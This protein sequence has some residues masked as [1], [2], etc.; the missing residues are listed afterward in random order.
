MWDIYIAK[1]TAD[2]FMFVALSAE[3][4]LSNYGIV[5]IRHHTFRFRV[6]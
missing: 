2:L 1:K 6:A 4:Y 5:K 3:N